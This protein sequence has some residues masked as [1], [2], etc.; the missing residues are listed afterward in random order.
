MQ[1]VPVCSVYSYAG[2]VGRALVC[3]VE[4]RIQENGHGVPECGS[5]DS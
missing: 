1:E 2:A 4:Q 5:A 3:Q